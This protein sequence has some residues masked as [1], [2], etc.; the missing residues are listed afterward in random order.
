MERVYKTVR[1]SREKWSIIIKRE[2]YHFKGRLT[3][4]NCFYTDCKKVRFDYKEIANLY[5]E[6]QFIKYGRQLTTYWSEDCGCYH[7]R[8]SRIDDGLWVRK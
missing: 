1:D 5:S 4:C 2:K 8:T 3:K 7:L 6:Y